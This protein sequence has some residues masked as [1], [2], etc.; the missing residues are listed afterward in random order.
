MAAT[1]AQYVQ[2]AKALPPRL[3]RFFAR[4]PHESI[5]PVGRT[6]EQ[7][8]TAYQAT[9]PN[10]FMPS[11]HPVTGRLH[12]PKYSLRRQAELVKLARENGVEELLPYTPKK[13]T[14]RLAKRVELGLRVKG[15]GVGQ[16]V[17]GHKHEREILQKYVHLW[18]FRA[19][20][21]SKSSCARL[22]HVPLVNTLALQD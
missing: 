17:K 19:E 5:L 7:P 8:H 9:T 14:E 20:A 4:Y 3:Q 18:Q 16:T 22:R 2:L 15:T 1:A 11:R 12:D 10:P 21:S 13:T 6:S